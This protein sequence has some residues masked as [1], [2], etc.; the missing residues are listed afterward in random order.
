MTNKQ[1][2]W[3]KKKIRNSSLATRYAVALAAAVLLLGVVFVQAQ[4]VKPELYKS[5]KYRHIGPKGNRVVAVAGVPGDPN[6]IY[7][8]AATG[9]VFKTT[10]GGV[11]W[12]PIFDQFEVQSIGAVAVADSDPNIVWVGTGEAFIRGHISIGNGVYKSTDA[13]KTWSHMGLNLTGRIARVIIN[14]KNPD[15]VYVAAMGHCYGPQQERGVYRTTDAG[16]TWEKVLFIDENTGAA[17]IVMD[18]NNPRILFA[19]MWQLIIYGWGRESGGPGSGLYMSRDGGTTWKHLT[20][21]G[22]PDPPLGKIGLAIAPSDSNRIYALIETADRGVLWRSENGGD[23]WALISSDETLNRRPH[24][25]SRMAVLP[26]NPNEV[27][28]LTQLE[29]HM[30]IDGGVTSRDVPAVWPDNHD[31]WIDP[32]NPSRLIVANDRYVNISTNRG[33][34][35]MRASLP[36]AQMY[37]VAVDDRIPYWVYGNRQD[38]PGHGAPSNTLNGKYILPADWQWVGG[39][40]SGFTYP[41]PADP[42]MVWSS[43]QAGFLQHLD[44]RTGLARNVNPWPVGMF[45][46]PIADLKYRLQWTFP[47][48]LSPN[49]PQRLYAGSQH[50]HVTEDAGQTWKVISPDLTTND[51]SKQQ[52]SGGLTP[53]NTSVEFYCVLFAIAESPVDRDVIWAGSNDGLVHVTR[54]GGSHWDNVT[55]AIPNL[56]P[57]GTVSKIEPSRYD[58]GAAYVTI[59][60]HQVNDRNPY[61]Y[62]TA[63]YGKSWKLIVTGI[64][65]SV[66]S[67]AHC[68]AEDPVRRG[69][70]YLGT[71]NSLY[72]SFDDGE[73]W[74][75][76]QNNLP[77]SR[78]SWIVVQERFKDLVISTYGRGF[79]ICDDITPLQQLDENVL[80]SEAHLFPPREAYRFRT[81]PTLPIYMGEEFDP[82]SALGH[83]PPYG[84]SINYFLGKEQA[85]EVKFEILD[86]DGNKIRKLKGSKEEGINRI[87]WDLKYETIEMPR[88]RTSPSGH[89]EIGLNAEGWRRFPMGPESGT[90]ATLVPPGTY[91]VKLKLGETERT[92][93]LTV[94]KDPNSLGS[95]EGILAATEIVFDLRNQVKDMTDMINRIESVRKQLADLKLRL[96]DGFE[97]LVVEAEEIESKLLAVESSFFDPHITGSADSFYYPPQLYMKLQALAADIAESDFPPTQAHLEVYRIYT[98]QVAEQKSKFDAIL[99]TDVAGFNGHLKAAGIPHIIQ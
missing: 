59:D 33:K 30:S 60:L 39:S 21:H 97:T 14:P 78:V 37:H 99:S 15:I 4:D 98:E 27:Y 64:P 35:W 25:Y 47:I 22:L 68:I 86:S 24:Y 82:P 85:E 70:L 36:N 2:Y 72:A 77:H 38:G 44:L 88:L 62:K 69:L 11:H 76:L 89:P 32:L 12:F 7:T 79:W 75:P 52:S 5:L 66:F 19:G 80:S 92:Q 74:Q 48:A 50:V 83:N 6:T 28:F 41:D 61:V 53:D 17:D 95:E 96:A 58:A 13:G 94:L 23:D 55:E 93:E 3:T 45:V 26:D 1:T 91:T 81:R 20:G 63:D 65:R 46:W 40:E 56:P 31:M 51:K 71:E 34:T 84:A 49:D 90:M 57:W 10:D 42:N 16:K 67:Y 8:G 73:H 43:G 9:G 54:D 29:M 18:P 87:W